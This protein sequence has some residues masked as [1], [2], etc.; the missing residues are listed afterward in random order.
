M[1]RALRPDRLAAAVRRWVGGAL[2]PEYV[3]A[4]PFDLA[5]CLADAGPGT[6]VLIFL[7]PGVDAAASV[8][9]LA[10]ARGVAGGAVAVSLGQGQ[11]PVAMDA[12][13]AAHARGGWVL[14]QNIHLTIDWTAGPLSAAVDKLGA[15][16]H[17]DFRCAREWRVGVERWW[18]G[19][20]GRRAGAGAERHRPRGRTPHQP[21]PPQH[22]PTY[23][24]H[25][26]PPPNSISLF[27]SAEPPPALERPLPQALLQACVKATNEPPE[28]L[29][30]NV[31][32][33]Y[34]NF[35]DDF[36]EA[37]SK[38]EAVWGVGG[39]R[40]GGWEGWS[41]RDGGGHVHGHPHCLAMVPAH[42]L[43]NAPN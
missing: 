15:G 40:G 18:F 30:A 37:C 12:L 22:P 24:P 4:A 34:S 39:R 3:E 16:A 25:H 42:S 35:S 26:H 1:F 23:I 43:L 27:L 28:G 7:S 17:P 33:A 9:A 6:P 8:E 38:V 31:L 5:R 10:R 19:G 20:R 11:E 29:R 21:S 13:R 14:L 41:G 2:G 32:R 36:F